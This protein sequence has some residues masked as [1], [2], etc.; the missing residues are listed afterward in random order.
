MQR[1]LQER[2][3]W[4]ATIFSHSNDAIFVMDP[5]RDKILDANPEACRMLG[6]S[7]DELLSIGVSTVHPDEMPKMLD[8]ARSVYRRE[9]GWTDELS[10]RTKRGDVLP[11]EISA[12]MAD[13]GGKPCMI[14]MVRDISDRKQADQ[15]L[16][17]AHQELRTRVEQQAAELRRL[18]ERLTDEVAE[19]RRLDEQFLQ[20]QRLAAIGRLA[21]GVAHDFNNIL[22]AI[23]GYAELEAASR[24]MEDRPSPGLLEIR[25]AAKRASDLTRQLLVFSGRK[26]AEPRAIDVNDVVLQSQRL[27]RGVI[28]EDIQLEAYRSPTPALVTSD[29]AQI[30]L[31]LVNLVVNARDA[32]Q[33]GGK[34]MIEVEAVTRRPD[35]SRGLD[36][37][38]GD[39]VTLAVA[40]TGAGMT[41]EVR[42]RIFEPFFT[43]KEPADGS[44]LGLSSTL[45][46]VKQIGG[47]IQ[48]ESEPGEGTTVRVYLPRA[49]A[50]SSESPA[51]PEPSQPPTGTETVLIVEDDPDVRRVTAIALRRF[52]YTVL[53]A[54]NGD[55]ALRLA[56]APSG[57]EVDLLLADLVM[58]LMGGRELA[59]RL[60]QLRPELKVLYTSGY[61]SDM[62]PRTPDLGAG[63][64]QKPYL[65]SNLAHKVREVLDEGPADTDRQS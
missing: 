7:R 17:S 45:A 14:A 25:R 4:L 42:S 53:E 55:E 9:Q 16:Q 60:R 59:S 46:I 27:L 32:M 22:S 13:L 18:N 61:P 5:P 48:V 2:E 52:G 31:V 35:G 21:G 50:D 41:E 3:Q 10:C 19:R 8:F 39:Y 44:G 26:A 38:P 15:T 65:P 58:P 54:S 36:L 34:L 11:S 33:R 37:P 51:D 40:D 6:Y 47:D 63:F 24:S 56:R 62:A 64:M 49:K 57:R 23:I 29:P 43:T 12:S 30:E 1:D 20:S 28:G